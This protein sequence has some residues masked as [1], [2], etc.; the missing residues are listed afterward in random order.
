M[1]YI[2]IMFKK[3]KIQGNN[4]SLFKKHIFHMFFLNKL[5]FLSFFKTNCFKIL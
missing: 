3:E 1:Q 4:I 5:I 2:I